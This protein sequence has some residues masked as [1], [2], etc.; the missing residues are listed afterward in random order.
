MDIVLHLRGA[1][2]ILSR[3]GSKQWPSPYPG[4][5]IAMV[6]AA[7]LLFNLSSNIFGCA[8]GVNASKGQ[9]SFI[10]LYTCLH[11]AAQV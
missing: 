7:Q 6:Q 4:A 3:H 2:A 5:G 11:D 9:L 1:F 8:H 10:Y